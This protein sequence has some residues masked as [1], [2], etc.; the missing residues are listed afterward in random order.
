MTVIDH[1]PATRY[2]LRQRESI[3]AAGPRLPGPR[4]PGPRLPGQRSSGLSTTRSLTAGVSTARTST[5][6][7]S[8]ATSLVPAFPE[9]RAAGTVRRCGHDGHSRSARVLPT[10]AAMHYQGSGVSGVS[11]VIATRAAHS[12][13]RVSTLV[14]FA[15]A[16][17][18]AMITVWLG[19][20]GQAGTGSVSPAHAVPQ[21]PDQLAV[22][23]VQVGETLHQL[24]HRV[25]P[26]LPVNHV[27]Q[28]IRELNNLDATTVIAGQTLISPLE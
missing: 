18:T 12:D 7:M 1:R 10:T 9:H 11:G 4:L 28:R 24:A 20:L 16:G 3:R 27:V 14:T 13:K 8:T 25:A 5:A 22:V 23:R 17:L 2:E 21:M 26:D 6:G 15:L 19:V